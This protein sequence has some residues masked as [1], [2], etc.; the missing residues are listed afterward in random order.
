MDIDRPSIGDRA[1]RLRLEEEAIKEAERI[2]YEQDAAVEA[3]RIHAESSERMYDHL[4]DS[5]RVKKTESPKAKNMGIPTY[6]RTSTVDPGNIL[7]P[8]EAEDRYDKE[9]ADI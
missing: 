4:K 2:R 3:R 6:E 8:L 1:D 9:A 5:P 7:F